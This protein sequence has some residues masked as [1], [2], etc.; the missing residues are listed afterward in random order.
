MWAQDGCGNLFLMPDSQKQG[1]NSQTLCIEFPDLQFTS[2]EQSQGNA[3]VIRFRTRNS[4]VRFGDVLLVLDGP[5][6]RFHGLIGQI[7]GDG[8]AVATDRRG[9]TIPAT[10]S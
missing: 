1:G 10:V 8:W 3:T 2:L 5:D 7:D 6:I 9:S 4:E